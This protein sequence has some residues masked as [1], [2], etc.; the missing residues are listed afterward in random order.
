MDIGDLILSFITLVLFLLFMFNPLFRKL[1]KSF[2]GEEE[3]AERGEDRM[4]ESADSRR[5]VMNLTEDGKKVVIR[6]PELPESVYRKS[7]QRSV[8][9]SPVHFKKGSLKQAVIWKEVLGPPRS[10]KPYGDEDFF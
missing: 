1:L 9:K 4:Y 3:D 6:E 7:I 10:L 8:E 2:Q 5:V